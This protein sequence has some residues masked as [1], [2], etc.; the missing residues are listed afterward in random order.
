MDRLNI[1]ILGIGDVQWP[2]AG[3]III[4]NKIVYYSG[5]QDGLHRYGVGI[6]VSR[7]ISQSVTSFSPYSNRILMI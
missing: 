5:S 7:N 1:D 6:I 4:D 2:D 3:K